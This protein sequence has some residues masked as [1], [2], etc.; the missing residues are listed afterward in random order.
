GMALPERDLFPPQKICMAWQQIHSVGGGLYSLGNTCFNSVLQ[1]LT[2]TLPLANYLLSQEH[3][4]AEQGFCMKCTME[5]HI[6][7]VLSC[8]SSAIEPTPVISELLRIGEHFQLGTQEDTHEFFCYAV[9]AMQ[10]ACLSRSSDWDT[11]S[12]ASTLIRQV[13]GGFLRSRVTCLS[14]KAVSDTYK[15]FLDI[16]LYQG[17]I[18]LNSTIRGWVVEWEENKLQPLGLCLFS[19]CE[20]LATVSKRL[21]IHHSSNVLTVCLKRFD[22]FSGRKISKVVQYLEYLDLGAYMS[23]AAG[24]PLLYSLYAILV[25]EASGCQTGHYYCFIKAG[26]GRWYKM[27]DASVVLCNAKMVLCQCAYSL[28]YAR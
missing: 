5:E 14:C 10:K 6:E 12:Q 3:S 17:K 11:S 4:Q 23:Q 16:P 19:R 28:F 25:Y 24:E 26:D 13:F 9:D 1:G 27:N 22:A 2:Y 8:S 20:Q 15:V 21:T 18:S 7:E